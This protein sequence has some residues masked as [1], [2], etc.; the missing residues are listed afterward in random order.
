MTPEFYT[1]M[2][3]VFI[4]LII[5][6]YDVFALICWGPSSTIS[7]VLKYIDECWRILSYT[8]TFGL[9]MLVWHF[10]SK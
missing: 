9:G 3:I 1:G 5:I 7:N 2:F 8:V 6:V 10:F 4:V